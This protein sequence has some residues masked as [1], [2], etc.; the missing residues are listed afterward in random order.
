MLITVREGKIA[1]LK[2]FQSKADA[3]EAVGLS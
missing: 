2:A 3:L 1:H